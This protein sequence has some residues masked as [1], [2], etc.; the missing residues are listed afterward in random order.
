MSQ[1][2]SAG[3]NWGSILRWI[4]AILWMALIFFMS[5]QPGGQ[6]GNL[7]RLILEYLASIGIDMQAWFGDN[8][9]WVIRKLAHF[10]EY[11]ILFW[12]V[13]FGWGDFRRNKWKILLLCILY[14]A[15][16]EFHQL[17]VPGRVGDWGDVAIDSTGAF[18][19]LGIR[20]LFTR[21]KKL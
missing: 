7:S 5:S 12:L 15:S 3:R 2:P 17:F 18:T 14:A 20:A 13:L 9:F 16:D 21:R 1:P 11:F 6:S 4:P 8:A 19:A 10:G